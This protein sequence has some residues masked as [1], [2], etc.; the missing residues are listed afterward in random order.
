[1][2]RAQP[3]WAGWGFGVQMEHGWCN[4]TPRL[5][6]LWN[7]SNHVATIHDP[8]SR[9]GLIYGLYRSNACCLLEPRRVVHGNT[10]MI[11]KCR[12]DRWQRFATSARPISASVRPFRQSGKTGPLFIGAPSYRAGAANRNHDT[13]LL[14]HCLGDRT[15][16]RTYLRSHTKIPTQPLYSPNPAASP[17]RNRFDCERAA[18]SESTPTRATIPFER[19]FY[20]RRRGELAIVACNFT[21]VRRA[22]SRRRPTP[23]FYL[24]RALNTASASYHARSN[25]G[26]EWRPCG[27]IRSPGGR[28]Y[29]DSRRQNPSS[30]RAV[31]FTLEND[32][33]EP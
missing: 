1:M 25:V 29:S 23:G 17:A 14:L 24:P 13:A 27:P 32:A 33:I 12:G 2:C 30:A 16:R 7:R 5:T 15:S 21:P 3:R 31:I 22:D 6:C 28:T 19:F 18:S 10:P 9:S 26:N 11:G 8:L 20:A 4:L